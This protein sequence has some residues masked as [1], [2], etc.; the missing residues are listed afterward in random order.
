MDSMRP[1]NSVVR[2]QFLSHFGSRCAKFKRGRISGFKK[3]KKLTQ[4]FWDFFHFSTQFIF[5]GRSH[6]DFSDS[7]SREPQFNLNCNLKKNFSETHRMRNFSRSFNL[8]PDD[9]R[10]YFSS[11]LFVPIQTPCYTEMQKC[12]NWNP[13]IFLILCLPC[14]WRKRFHH[15]KWWSVSRGCMRKVIVINHILRFV[16]WD[17]R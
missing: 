7:L 2:P 3:E 11:L 16:S 13:I 8:L 6:R 4:Y 10:T 14:S 12:R 15:I 9:K 5:V 17:S 1:T